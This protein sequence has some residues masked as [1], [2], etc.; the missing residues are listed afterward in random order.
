[1]KKFLAMVRNPNLLV[2][3][4]MGFSSGLPL[5]LVG[6]TLRAWMREA[7]VDLKTI[8]FFSIVTLPYTWKFIWAPVMDRYVL[9]LGRRRGWLIL[10]QLLLMGSLVGLSTVDPASQTLTLA[11]WAFLVSFFSASQDVVV[12]AYRREILPNEQLG[13]GSSLYV[14]AYRVALLVAGAGAFSLSK[15]IPWS[16]VYIVMAVF[17]VVGI[18]TTLM[19]KEPT[20]DAPPP[21]TLRESVVGPLKDFFSRESAW[22]LLLFVL[23]YK[24]GESMA[25]DMFNPLYIDLRIDKDAV[26]G[27]AKG[28]GFWATVT[29]G[30]VGGMLILRLRLYRALWI[31]GILQSLGLLLFAALAGV[32]QELL[33]VHSNALQDPTATVPTAEILPLL[34]ASIGFENFASGMATSAFVALMALQTNKRFTATQYALLSSLTGVS[35]TFFG[36]TTGVIAESLGW[37]GFFVACTL[38]TVPGLLILPFIKKLIDETR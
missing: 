15:R 38:I 9:P 34:A 13:F 20:V 22:I 25:S 27:V 18:I 2:V 7:H 21:K 4:L 1:M 19:A 10:S 37:K 5:L 3:F 17:M 16:T 12:D 8:G 33:V 11:V 24:L 26:A 23:L 36:M 6:G 32:G 14:F 29:G 28:F 35:R 31:F 30:M